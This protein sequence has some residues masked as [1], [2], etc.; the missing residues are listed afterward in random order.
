[1]VSTLSSC[2]ESM[3]EQVFTM[4]TSASAAS[5]VISTPS[6]SSEPSM[7]SASTRF[8]AQPSEIIPTR[9]GAALVFDL[10][11]ERVA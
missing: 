6:L 10:F 3:N 1:M 11:T 2:A 7:I 5:F 8:L 9:T 4:T